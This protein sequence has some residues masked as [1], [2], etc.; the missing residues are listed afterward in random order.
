MQ[1]L[2][3]LEEQLRNITGQ[4]DSLRQRD[5]GRAIT[6]L[7]EELA[8]IGRTL[9][10]ALPRHAIETIERRIHDLTKRI[11]EGKQAGADADALARIERGLGEVRD[12]LRS[13]T[14]AENLVGFNEA[15]AGLARKIDLIV[16]QRDP[17][18]FA[19]L[20]NTITTL[21]TM[22]NHIASNETVSRLGA[23][24]QALGEKIEHFAKAT[25]GGGTL[26]NLEYRIAT[27][28]DAL[29]ERSQSAIRVAAAGAAAGATGRQGPANPGF[30]RRRQCRLGQ[31][32]A[33]HC[34]ARR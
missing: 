24:V 13:L 28:S 9:N 18:T 14:P 34:R 26:N 30:A 23:E 2:S 29:A 15:V 27:L 16:A 31:Y 25:A 22:A 3:G 10:E 20:E 19:Q 1:N 6:A 4:I 32:R 8:E 11:A 5:V 21:R 7:R 17:E 33:S 12:A